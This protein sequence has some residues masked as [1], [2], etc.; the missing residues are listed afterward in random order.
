M[1]NGVSTVDPEMAARVRAAVARL[2]LRRNSMAKGSS[3]R[4]AADAAA[5]RE[6][7]QVAETVARP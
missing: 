5:R 7:G 3:T 1:V 2:G 6:G 4:A